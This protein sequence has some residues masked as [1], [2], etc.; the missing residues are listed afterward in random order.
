MTAQAMDSGWPCVEVC[1][2]LPML[3]VLVHLPQFQGEHAPGQRPVH[4]AAPFAAHMLRD[5][6]PPR[7]ASQQVCQ[8]WPPQTRDSPGTLCPRMRVAARAALAAPAVRR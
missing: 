4:G 7:V 1:I 8:G 5:T 3:Y 2:P 6:T